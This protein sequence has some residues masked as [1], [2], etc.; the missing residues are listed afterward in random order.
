[1]TKFWLSARTMQTLSIIAMEEAS[2]EGRKDADLEHLLVALVLSDQPA[3]DALRGLGI[4][5]ESARRAVQQLRA[6]QL[7]SLGVEA[8][9]PQEGRIVFHEQRGH[10]WTDRAME[11]FRQASGRGRDGGASDVLKTLVSEPSGTVEDL[12][13][14]LGT[15]PAQVTEAADEAARAATPPPRAVD[16]KAT[17]S[18]AFVPAPQDAVWDFISDPSKLPEWMTWHST[19]DAPAG[20]LKVGDAFEGRRTPGDTAP[21]GKNARPQYRRKV[22][23]LAL[24][25]P[26]SRIAWRVSHPDAP[27]TN[28]NQVRITLEPV[29]GGTRVT[30]RS[31][32][33]GPRTWRKRLFAPVRPA[34]VALSWMNTNQ[35]AIAISRAFR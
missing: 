22:I 5:L 24:L 2:R 26:R 25:E 20:A 18:R 4:T 34:M 35:H 6:D 31:A 14:R 19:I 33:L 8:A 23:E 30:A 28:A 32:W 10:E 7:A 29:P 3:G 1:M 11:V 21:G 27:H 17:T 9:A 13:A 16:G 12:L 15:D